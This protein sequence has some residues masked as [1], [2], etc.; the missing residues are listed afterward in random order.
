[1]AWA[2]VPVIIA[3]QFPFNDL[4]VA[5]GVGGLLDQVVLRRSVQ[6]GVA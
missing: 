1:M 3:I 6:L 4:A 2:I 5:H